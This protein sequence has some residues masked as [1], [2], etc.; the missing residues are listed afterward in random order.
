MVPLNETRAESTASIAE[1]LCILRRKVATEPYLWMD[2]FILY[3]KKTYTQ[4]TGS[5]KEM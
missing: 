4:R 2:A 1:I 5:C 3:P